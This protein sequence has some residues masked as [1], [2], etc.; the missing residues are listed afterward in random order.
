[1]A[2]AEGRI[3]KFETEKSINTG[4]LETIRYDGGR[5]VIEYRTREFSAVCPFSGLPDI[6]EVIIRYV[7]SVKIVELKSLKYY[8]ISFRN[9]GIYQEKATDRIFND[10]KK[11]LK[12]KY[13]YVETVYNTRGG[14]DAKCFM[15]AGSK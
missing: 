11:L 5:Q 6:A 15:E 2:K 14:I 9:V 13:L 7:P 3:F 12:P 1:M 8:F 10:L 4:L